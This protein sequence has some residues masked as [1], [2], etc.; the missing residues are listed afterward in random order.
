MSVLTV[1]LAHMN[2]HTHLHNTYTQ[3]HTT[4][5]THTHT[6]THKLMHTILTLPQ[7]CSYLK[8]MI[9]LKSCQ[10]YRKCSGK[11]QNY[12]TFEKR[13]ILQYKKKQDC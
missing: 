8:N 6:H 9:I 2:A 5:H 13:K 12:M 10:D 11:L 1:V 4:T 3:I 7:L